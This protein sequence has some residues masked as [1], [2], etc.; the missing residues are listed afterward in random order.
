M[1][2]FLLLILLL[3]PIYTH[4]YI[5]EEIEDQTTEYTY[6]DGS[7]TIRFEARSDHIVIAPSGGVG[8]GCGNGYNTGDGMSCGLVFKMCKKNDYNTSNPKVTSVLPFY[9]LQGDSSDTIV[10]STN[11]QCRFKLG[12]TTYEG[13]VVYFHFDNITSQFT[14]INNTRE[15]YRWGA[16]VTVQASDSGFYSMNAYTADVI[17]DYI[18]NAYDAW[19]QVKD[20]NTQITQNNQI[21]QG[22]TDINN[23]LNDSSTDNETD[24]LIGDLFGNTN[25]N[26]FGLQDVLLAPYTF[27]NATTR[28]CSAMN[29]NILGAE[30]TIP[31]GNDIFWDKPAVAPLKTVWNILF[32]GAAVYMVL[33]SLWNSIQGAMDPL[34]DN[35]RHAKISTR[36]ANKN[37]D[38]GN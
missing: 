18:V 7:S 35:V 19:L 20:G 28:N 32:G 33:I 5:Q 11:I 31:C 22:N 30:T 34:S 14:I 24:S 26:D 13:H 21:I 2:K 27:L 29:M 9:S 38:G 16:N 4:A 10:Y 12:G 17:P 3:F 36:I 37:K 23:S 1:K 6:I 15:Y 25:T 8:Y